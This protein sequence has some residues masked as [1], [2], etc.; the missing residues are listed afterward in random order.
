MCL[1]T[2]DRGGAQRSSRILGG[3]SRCRARLPADPPPGRRK[4]DAPVVAT[5]RPQPGRSAARDQRPERAFV[6]GADAAS[7]IV[8]EPALIALCDAQ[9]VIAREDGFAG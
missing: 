6:D 9:L 5:V 4:Q 8:A 2:R 7:P 3:F 1:K